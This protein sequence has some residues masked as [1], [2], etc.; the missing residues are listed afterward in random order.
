[1]FAF[2]KVALVM[3]SLHRNGNPK[4]GLPI[5][6]SYGDIFS[7]EVPSSQANEKLSNTYTQVLYVCCCWELNTGLCECEARTRCTISQPRKKYFLWLYE[8]THTELLAV[9]SVGIAFAELQ[10]QHSH[11]QVIDLPTGN[12]KHPPNLVVCSVSQQ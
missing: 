7:I 12:M 4:T 6:G 8:Q 10:D 1:M 3:V 11:I 2:L 9:C 5:A